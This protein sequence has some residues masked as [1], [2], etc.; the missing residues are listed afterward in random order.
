MAGP[1]EVPENA[2]LSALDAQAFNDFWC[3]TIGAA[4]CLELGP[5][6]ETPLTFP[7]DIGI[8]CFGHLGATFLPPTI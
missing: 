3:H 6:R 5:E 7:Q 2:L 4:G 8:N 1:I